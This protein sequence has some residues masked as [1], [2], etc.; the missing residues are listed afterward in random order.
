MTVQKNVFKLDTSQ[1]TLLILVSILLIAFILP[2]NIFD[3]LTVED[4]IVEN[5]TALFFLIA[6]IL[7]FVL[8]ANPN[9]FKQQEYRTTYSNFKNRIPL[10]LL[11]LVFFI[12]FGE[13]ISWGQRIFGIETTEYMQEH[14]VQ[15]EINLHNLEIFNHKTMDGEVKS[16]WKA[17][18]KVKRLFVMAFVFYL[19]IIP[20][21][22]RSNTWFKQLINKFHI[23]IAPI[24]L[25]LYFVGTYFVY[26]MASKVLEGV[27]YTEFGWGELEEFNLAILLVLV[28]LSWIDFS[29]FSK[30]EVVQD[31]IV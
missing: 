29:T 14:N 9:R 13:E 3:Y 26:R 2:A 5:F 25:G 6:S 4:G 11:G 21:L 28:P 17:W 27:K 20:Y 15:G 31:P 10:I 12:S 24:W 18:L 1:I 19:L 7:C 16:G 30:K 8:V 23:P 22:Y